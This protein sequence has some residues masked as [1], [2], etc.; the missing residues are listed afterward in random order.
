MSDVRGPFDARRGAKS[1]V[2]FAMQ[3]ETPTEKLHHE[4]VRISIVLFRGKSE[5]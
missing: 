1:I 2:Q 4:P 3:K 5:G